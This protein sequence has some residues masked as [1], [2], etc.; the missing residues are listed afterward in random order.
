MN[1][2]IKKAKEELS[3][4]LKIHQKLILCSCEV[5]VVVL[6]CSRLEVLE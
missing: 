2:K 5:N 4:N 1:T 6:P 3:K